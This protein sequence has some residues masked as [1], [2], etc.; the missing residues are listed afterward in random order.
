MVTHCAL[1]CTRSWLLCSCASTQ[2]VRTE[3]MWLPCF[4]LLCSYPCLAPPAFL[5][6]NM[7]HSFCLRVLSWEGTR[8]WWMLKTEGCLR[9][10]SGHTEW[11]VHPARPAQ[12]RGDFSHD[13]CTLVNAAPQWHSILDRLP[14]QVPVASPHPCSSS[15]IQRDFRSRC[16]PDTETSSKVRYNTGGKGVKGYVSPG[17][18]LNSEFSSA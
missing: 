13:L 2:A 15:S 8:N 4:Y 1:C 16:G 17:L 10:T 12:Q 5:A 18:N 11:L 3:E 9:A 7:P 14:K 6:E